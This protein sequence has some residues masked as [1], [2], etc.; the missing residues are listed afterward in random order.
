M[1]CYRPSSAPQAAH[2]KW[3]DG[4]VLCRIW[5]RWPGWPSI[6]AAS[7][8]SSTGARE[9][10]TQGRLPR[11]AYRRYLS[12]N[13]NNSLR[14]FLIFSYHIHVSW[15]S[16][17]V[18]VERVKLLIVIREVFRLKPAPE[19][20]LTWSLF[21]SVPPDE[22]CDSASIST[23]QFPS[24]STPMYYSLTDLPFDTTQSDILTASLSSLKY[25]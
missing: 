15:F 18:E 16:N 3:R 9:S 22:R 19:N 7:L 5:V 1:L 4:H 14:Q 8:S 25:K 20:L 6:R 13:A 11:T 10:G 2:V 21:S 24:T 12:D 23:P 17:N